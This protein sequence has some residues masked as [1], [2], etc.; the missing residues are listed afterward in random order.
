MD[1]YMDRSPATER[2]CE[3]GS[4]RTIS[5][6]DLKSCKRNFELVK[7]D[8]EIKL[9]KTYANKKAFLATNEFCLN[10]YASVNA[11]EQKATI[12]VKEQVKFK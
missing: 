5:S 11:K 10:E 7:H 1:F 4:S 8:D 3:K 12:C 9:K 2:D 6:Q